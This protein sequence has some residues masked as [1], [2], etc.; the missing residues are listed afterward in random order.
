MLS[1]SMTQKAVGRH[2]S[3]EKAL[4]KTEQPGGHEN[5]E[6]VSQGLG[7]NLLQSLDD[8]QSQEIFVASQRTTG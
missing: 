4:F 6:A 5:R 1:S 3:G 2:H 8:R 7:F